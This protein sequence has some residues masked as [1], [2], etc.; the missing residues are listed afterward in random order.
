MVLVSRG[1]AIVLIIV[2]VLIIALCVISFLGRADAQ[3]AALIIG[4]SPLASRLQTEQDMNLI[5][6]LG[7]FI[8]MF[9]FLFKINFFAELGQDLRNEMFQPSNQQQQQT[10]MTM[11]PT[12]NNGGFTPF[13]VNVNPFVQQPPQQMAPMQGIHF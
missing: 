4:E 2:A 11:P 7:L 8:F 3:S 12:F 1:S 9:V 5:V 6:S 10:L 13:A